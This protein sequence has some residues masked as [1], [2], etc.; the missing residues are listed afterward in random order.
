MKKL[1]FIGIIHRDLKPANILLDDNLYLKICDFG[2][3][4]ISD[5]ELSKIQMEDAAETPIYMAPKF[6]SD[7]I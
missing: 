2:C 4:I 3:S 1:H 6:F 7:Y 5:V